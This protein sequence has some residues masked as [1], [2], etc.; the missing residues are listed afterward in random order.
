[1][2]HTYGKPDLLNLS[3]VRHFA[4]GG[5]RLHMPS[6]VADITWIRLDLKMICELIYFDMLIFYILGLQFTF[7]TM[8]KETDECL[9]LKYELIFSV[10]LAVI[11]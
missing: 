7:A 10:W 4:R 2:L 6:G 9:I 11:K 5:M 3:N 8:K 1:M